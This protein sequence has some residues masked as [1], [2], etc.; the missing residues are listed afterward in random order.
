MIKLKFNN[1]QDLKEYSKKYN[2]MMVCSCGRA[3]G[4]FNFMDDITWKIHKIFCNEESIRTPKE[5]KKDLN[6]RK[7][8]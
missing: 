4:Y 3:W 8:E 1:I 6:G 7:D 5:I 2:G